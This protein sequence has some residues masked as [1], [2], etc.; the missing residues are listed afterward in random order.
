MTVAQ[1]P[2]AAAEEFEARLDRVQS[3]LAQHDLDYLLI[4]PSTDMVYLIAFPVRQS[5]R[6]TILVIPREGTPRLVMPGFELPRVR[7]LPALFEPAPWEDGDDP[8]L[9]LASLLEADGAGPTVGVAGQLFSHFLFRLQA[10]A[11][12]AQ[13]RPGDVL[14]ERVRMRKSPVE[15]E[16]LRAAGHAADAVFEELLTLPVA[17]MTERD[18]LTEIHRLLLEK[19][20]DTIGGGIAAF[21]ANGASPHH[22]VSDRR[23]ASGDAVV[24]DFG[25][26]R[27]DYRSDLT[28][29]FHLGPPS[30]EFRRVYET[31]NE[32]NELA[33]QRVRPGVTAE[34]LDAAA[35]EHITAAGYGD[36]FLHRLGHG[37]GLDGHEAP[38][39][40]RG[41]TTVIEEGMTFSIEPGIYLQGRFG[42]RIED[43]VVAT[44]DGAER[45]NR[46]THELQVI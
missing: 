45:L 23:A 4:G 27:R 1:E 16:A 26:V 42:V 17:G 22:G 31:V 11:P 7:S 35:R 32:A 5:E 44:F 20:H 19:G 39:L 34:A 21:G 33:F 41:D 37:I 13:W 38:Y 12:R 30:D 28:R 46:S 2:R 3:E 29:T 10:A 8:S 40:V 15:V 24:V 14:M 36:A 43:I 25:G 6:M 18:V 9:L